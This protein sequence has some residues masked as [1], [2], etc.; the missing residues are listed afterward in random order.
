MVK[1]GNRSHVPTKSRFTTWLLKQSNTLKRISRTIYQNARPYLALKY[2]LI[3]GLAFCL[4]FYLWGPSQGLHKFQ[5]W[6]HRLASKEDQLQTRE[7]LQ[8]Q[9]EQLKQQLQTAQSL[10][11]K[12]VF[13][14][15]SFS[16]PALGQIIR[17][18]DWIKSGNSWRLHNGVDIGLPPGSNII[19]AAAGTV[20]DIKESGIGTYSVTV[21][22]GDGWT[23]LYEDLATVMVKKGQ[24]LIKGVII[25]TSGNKGCDPSVPNFHFAIYHDQEVIDPQ[26][27]IA[28]MSE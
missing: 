20:A 2:W 11:K 14:P 9:L 12:P 26:K 16:R 3:Y 15:V 23:S 28:G 25:G 24:D 13:D 6:Q 1:K 19:A 5:T 18:F 21:D 8:H 10:Q 7:T 17:G 22:H 4:G 27:I